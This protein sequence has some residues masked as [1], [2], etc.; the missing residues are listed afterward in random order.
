MSWDGVA[1]EVEAYAWRFSL[2]LV[3]SSRQF[4]DDWLAIGIM[5]QG[6]Q[7]SRVQLG[8]QSA[9][10]AETR[11]NIGDGAIVEL[12][13][14]IDDEHARAEHL[15]IVHIMGSEQHCNALLGIDRQQKFTD[16]RLRHDIQS[17]S[18]FVQVVVRGRAKEPPPGRHACAA[19]TRAGA[20]AY[21]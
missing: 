14:M 3:D 17:N 5:W 4:S 18:W 15:N 8:N 21:R 2:H 19:L 7:F 10:T 20:Q 1:L 13:S 11:P 6:H 12:A 9:F 16:T